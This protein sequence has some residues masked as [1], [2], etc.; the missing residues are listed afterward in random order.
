MELYINDI[1]F[2]KVKRYYQDR[3]NKRWNFEFEDKKGIQS[4][5]SIHF[6][7]IKSF[8]SSGKLDILTYK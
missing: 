8:M 1:F 3:K 2:G 6:S 7:K 5:L 4:S